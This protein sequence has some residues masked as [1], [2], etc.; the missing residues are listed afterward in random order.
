[1]DPVDF[2]R[3]NSS[4]EEIARRIALQMSGFSREMLRIG[5]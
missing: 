4:R 5:N 1:L 2:T 3:N